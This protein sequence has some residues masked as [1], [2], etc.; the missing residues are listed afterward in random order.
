M[1]TVKSQESELG[2]T[3]RTSTSPL[4][5]EPRARDANPTDPC[6][7]V[8]H[9]SLRRLLLD[10]EARRS[11]VVLLVDGAETSGEMVLLEGQPFHA[12]FEGRIGSAA[13]VALLETN[14]V[15]LRMAMP[16]SLARYK[17]SISL[18]L[19]ELGVVD[20]ALAFPTIDEPRAVPAPL[21]SAL[22]L[23][24]TEP[25]DGAVII[26]RSLMRASYAAWPVATPVPEGVLHAVYVFGEADQTLHLA[27]EKLGRALLRDVVAAVRKAGVGG[28][29]RASLH[30]MVAYG[31]T[32][33]EG[34]GCLVATRENDDSVA[35][36]V[37]TELW[38]AL[39]PAA[40]RSV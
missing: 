21:P 33:Q 39:A 25:R 13:F 12:S 37:A 1:G 38:T 23:E 19:G 24:G 3:L 8:H 4:L 36:T 30:G 35:R 34:Y 14:V 40:L 31:A 18:G 27:G 6:A 11:S 10:C 26:S 22:E 5:S 20:E 7:V 16:R 2:R 17:R 15:L 28:L 9:K 29:A 32:S